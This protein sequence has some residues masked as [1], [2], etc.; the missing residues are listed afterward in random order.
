[1]GC[2]V[3][4]G[5]RASLTFASRPSVSGI[6]ERAQRQRAEHTS[7]TTSTAL[8]T[9]CSLFSALAMCPGSKTCSV[10]AGHGAAAALGGRCRD[11]DTTRSAPAPLC[12]RQPECQRYFHD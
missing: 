8:S 3:E 5:M 12:T 10:S 2:V 7:T 11:L 4:I 6:A 9:S 1:M